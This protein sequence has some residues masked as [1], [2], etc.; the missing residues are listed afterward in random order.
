[1]RVGGFSEHLSLQT[2]FG[3]FQEANILNTVLCIIV[4]I[5]IITTSDIPELSLHAT[6]IITILIITAVVFDMAIMSIV[7][8]AM[9]I[10]TAP[11]T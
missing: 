6:I 10:N 3:P 11:P 4:V 8:L 1:M 9:M 2:P 7:N 5:T